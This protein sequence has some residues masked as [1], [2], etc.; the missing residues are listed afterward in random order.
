MELEGKKTDVRACEQTFFTTREL[1]L[2]LIEDSNASRQS[3]CQ[4]ILEV[5]K[6]MGQFLSEVA[7]SIEDSGY[8]S[9]NRLLL[10]FTLS[11]EASTRH[12]FRSRIKELIEILQNVDYTLS[13]VDDE[14][15]RRVSFAHLL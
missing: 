11:K 3:V 5:E 7:S 4:K 9:L 2:G 10:Y 14:P 6:C 15:L 12:E 8:S 13:Q 1:L